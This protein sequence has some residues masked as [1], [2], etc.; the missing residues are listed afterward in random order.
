MKRTY[1]VTLTIEWDDEI[2][3]NPYDVLDWWRLPEVQPLPGRLTGV[4]ESVSR[5]L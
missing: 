4:K 1:E 3:D 2:D 5:Q